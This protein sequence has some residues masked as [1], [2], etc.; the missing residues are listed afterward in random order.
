MKNI[1]PCNKCPYK[2][3]LIQTLKNPCPQC[4]IEGYK[5]IDVF[6]SQTGYYGSEEMKDGSNKSKGVKNGV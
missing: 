1:S 2:L 5:M 4:K 3:G 6:R